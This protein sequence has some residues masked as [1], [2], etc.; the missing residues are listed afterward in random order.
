MN[1][2]MDI[3]TSFTDGVVTNGKIP[4]SLVST[5]L[6]KFYLDIAFQGPLNYSQNVPM[7]PSP[8]FGH[9]IDLGDSDKYGCMPFTDSLS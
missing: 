1:P 7:K 3:V 6:K 5:S 4:Q 8:E 9:G 2:S